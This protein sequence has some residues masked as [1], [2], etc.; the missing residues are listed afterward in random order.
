VALAKQALEAM[1]RDSRPFVRTF[2]KH[3]E[4]GELL[5]CSRQGRLHMLVRMA[6]IL[7]SCTDNQGRLA[8]QLT[9]KLVIY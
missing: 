9:R 8:N 1:A 2:F 5:P 7:A 4:D 3:D 6:E